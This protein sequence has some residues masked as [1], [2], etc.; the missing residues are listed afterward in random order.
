MNVSLVNENIQNL[1][2]LAMYI[3]LIRMHFDIIQVV[4][5]LIFFKTYCKRLFFY[6]I[7]SKFAGE[8]SFVLRTQMDRSWLRIVK[9]SKE[10]RWTRPGATRE[11]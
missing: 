11:R 8:K 4:K 1:K 6:I 5:L 10:H 7:D 3:T 9:S 2:K